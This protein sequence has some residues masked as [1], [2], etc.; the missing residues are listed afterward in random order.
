MKESNSPFMQMLKKRSAKNLEKHY[1]DP[2]V[3]SWCDI[4][5]GDEMSDK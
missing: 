5:Y 2:K 4:I 3:Q 1:G